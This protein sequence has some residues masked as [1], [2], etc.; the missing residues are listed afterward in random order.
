[1]C[2]HC[3]VDLSLAEEVEEDRKHFLVGLVIRVKARHVYY[4]LQQLLPFVTEMVHEVVVVVTNHRSQDARQLCWSDHQFF[5]DEL[6]SDDRL[7]NVVFK[8]I[9]V[10]NQSTFVTSLVTVFVLYQGY[11]VCRVNCN[12]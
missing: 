5:F 8:L 10:P 6:R 2:F 7:P 11:E 9:Y 1:M 12:W 4:H 3:Q